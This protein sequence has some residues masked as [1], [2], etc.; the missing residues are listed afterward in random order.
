MASEDELAEL[1]AAVQSTAE[2]FGTIV[3][4]FLAIMAYVGISVESTT[5]EQLLV[6][7]SINF[8]ILNAGIRCVPFYI[9]APLLVLLLHV[10]LLLEDYYLR[11]QVEHL[12]LQRVSGLDRCFSWSAMAYALG[13][14]PSWLV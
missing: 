2:R 9:F 7:G 10:D 4:T 14:R 12:R 1:K 3:L 6:N 8:P 5:D 11:H 13:W